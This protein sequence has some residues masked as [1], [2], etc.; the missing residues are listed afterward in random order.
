M[1]ASGFGKGRG[2]RGAASR[3]PEAVYLP[4]MVETISEAPNRIAT[5]KTT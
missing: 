3:Q 5:P 1:T 2:D 4:V